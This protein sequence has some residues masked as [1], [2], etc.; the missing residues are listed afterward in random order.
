MACP[1]SYF[2]KVLQRVCVEFKILP[3]LKLSKSS[4]PSIYIVVLGVGSI[5]L[6]LLAWSAHQ[7][8]IGPNTIRPLI[9][10][11]LLGYHCVINDAII[12]NVMYPW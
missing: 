1:K 11:I 5:L 3:Q 7:Q 12:W 8:K 10:A 6:G 9:G 4:V 2:L